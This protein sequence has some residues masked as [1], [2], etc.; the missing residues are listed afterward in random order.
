MKKALYL[1]SIFFIAL[2]G[3]SKE[4]VPPSPY[5]GEYK[6]TIIDS[7]FNATGTFTDTLYDHTIIVTKTSYSPA[8]FF[9][10]NGLIETKEGKIE[11]NNFIIERKLVSKDEFFETYEWAE[12]IFSGTANI[13]WTINFYREVINNNVVIARIK[14]YGVLVKQ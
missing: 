6:G 2:I 13:T 3:C 11:G 8:H 10:H 14:R 7:G 1:L 5:I 12:G 4:N 9:L